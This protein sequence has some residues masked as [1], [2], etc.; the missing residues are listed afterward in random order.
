MPAGSVGPEPGTAVGVDIGGT[1]IELAL[2]NSAGK[3]SQREE[4]ETRQFSGYEDLLTF[5]AERGKD[6]AG[7]AAGGK[8]VP[9]G[10]GVPGTVHGDG[11]LDFAPNLPGVWKQVPVQRI[12]AAAS[13]LRTFPINDANAAAFGEFHFGIGKDVDSLV[14]FTLGTGIGGGIVIDGKLLIGKRG[15]AAELGHMT[16]DI[17][18]ARCGC[19]NVGCL[20]ALAAIP[21]LVNRTFEKL[22]RGRE[23]ALVD[24]VRGD[25]EQINQEQVG[26]LLSK[27][28]QQKDAVALEVIEET[29][30]YIGAAVESAV[31]TL[32]PD[33]VVIGG[34]IAKIGEPLF[35]PIRRAVAARTPEIPFD[36][37]KIVP[38]ELDNAGLVGS[39][40]W[41][42]QQGK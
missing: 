35:A 2:V 25:L 10:V 21:A 40:A 16:I 13:G 29:A 24:L 37:S 23:S 3:V 41:A 26:F 9:I 1:T 36:L 42:M 28:A 39:A 7:T 17:N 38:A 20:E 30:A 22:Q 18:G 33:M 34:G 27:A 6:I 5:V 11:T 4:H 8:Q 12:V 32:D 14:L 15:R 19:G 31:M